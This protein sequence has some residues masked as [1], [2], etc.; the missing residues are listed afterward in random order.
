M[1]NTLPE[2]YLARHGETTW[3]LSGQHTGRTDIPLT[4]RGERHAVSLGT[5]LRG[6][7]FAQVQTSPLSRPHRTCELTGFGEWAQVDPD[8]QEWDYGQYEGRRTADI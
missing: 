7:T 2:I 6:A 8:L 3:S 1:E 4:P 5:R